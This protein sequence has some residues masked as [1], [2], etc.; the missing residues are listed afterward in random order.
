MTF[1][2]F[3]SLCAAAAAATLILAPAHA[4]ETA[5]KAAELKTALTPVGAEKA[6]NK[7]GTIPEWTGGVAP[8]TPAFVGAGSGRRADPYAEDK[9]LY[10][11]TATNMAEHA[12]QLTDG[13][14]ALLKK[15]PDT[16]RIDVY[17]TRRSA[18][19]PQWVYD[20]TF[21]NATRAK[22]SKSLVV[23]DAYGGVPFPIPAN[24]GE[25][26]ANTLLRWRGESWRITQQAY[27]GSADGNAV[28]TSDALLEQEM[29]YYFKDGSL[30]KF[31]GEYLLNRFV[32]SGPPIRAGEATVSRINVDE[33]KSRAWVYITGQRRVRML[34]NACC[35]TPA[36]PT[37]GV[38]TY[39][40]IFVFSGRMDRFNWRLVGKKEMLIPYNDNEFM[41]PK[42]TSDVLG[43]HHLNP[44]HVRWELHRVWVVEATLAPGARHS[45][46]RSLYYID[47][48]SWMAV[49]GDRF[50]ANGQLWKTLYQL[51]VVAPELPGMIPGAYGFVDML[52]GTWFANGLM[53]EKPNQLQYVPRFKNTNFTSDAL[54]GNGVY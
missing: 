14:K 23:E 39:D 48:D 32:V 21:K 33:D 38:M 16:Y 30:D 40:E 20:N 7:E 50:D 47:E 6:G 25:A 52:S 5:Q 26:M 3:S 46:V 35:D 9:K 1:A 42:K 41:Q 27:L 54:A 22:L 34:P 17:P 28:M 18:A 29:P 13:S 4:A 49:L 45:A 10:S 53:Q 43:V 44:D 36:A 37:S 31:N 51:P 8:S 24:G 12:D 11:V 15:F 19:A 2:S